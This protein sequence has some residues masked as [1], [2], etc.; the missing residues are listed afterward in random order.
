M[1]PG[2]E[3]IAPYLQ[4][5]AILEVAKRC[6]ADAIHPGYGFLSESPE[7]AA[8][9][10]AQNIKF[11]GPPPSA[12]KL[13]GDKTAAKDLAIRNNVPVA[14]GSPIL[15]TGQ[16]AVEFARKNNV[17]FPI[18]IKAAF[19]GGGRGQKL[20][21]NEKELLEG[22]ELCAKEALL[23]FGDGSCFVEE[24][25][26]HARHIEVQIIADSKHD[27]VSVYE[28]DCSVQLRNQKVIEVA[29]ARDMCA[30]LRTSLHEC[31]KRLAAAAGYVNAGTVEFLVRG[32]LSNEATTFIF[33]E[34]NPRI[35]VEHTITEEVCKVDLVRSQI[36]I[37]SG[38]SLSE[39]GLVQSKIQAHGFAIQL[40]VSL[41]PGKE[42]P[43]TQYTEPQGPGIRVDSGV[44]LGRTP[45]SQYDPMISKLIVYVD[46]KEGFDACI[47]KALAALDGYTMEGIR[48]NKDQLHAIL[49]HP[50]FVQNKVL[51]TFMKD[52]AQELSKKPAL[53]PAKKPAKE[54]AAPVFAKIKIDAPF[55]GKVAEVR[56]KVG[57]KIEGNQVLTV[58]SAMKMMNEINSPVTGTVVE[59][60]PKLVV[61]TQINEGDMMLVVEGYVMEQEQGHE[62]EST[63]PAAA[64]AAVGGGGGFPSE[65]YTA[66]WFREGT[67]YG[68]SPA[69]A[70]IRSKI[71][72]TTDAYKKR[73][74]HNKKVIGELQARLNLVKEGGGEK[75]VKVHRSRGKLLPRERVE[76][77]VDEGTK[78]LELSALAAWGLY[79]NKVH[80]AGMVCGIG[81]VHGTECMFIINDAT[82]KGG[83][84]FPETLKKMYRAQAIAQENHLP[85][86][87]L[88]DGGGAN[89]SA[90]EGNS[91]QGSAAAFVAGGSQFY[92]QA[93]MSSLGIP[94]ISA[95]LG[96]CTAGGAYIP[97]MSDENV[98]VKG[99]GTI[100]LGGPPLVKAAT[101]EVANEQDLGGAAM[102][103]SKSGVADHLAET[104]EEALQKVRCI[105]EHLARRPRH[106]LPMATPE[107]PAYDVDQLLGII[108]EDNKFPFDIREVIARI[109][110]GSRFHEFKPRYGI[111]LVCGFAHIHGFPV[112]ILANNGMLFSDSAIKGTHF[113]QVCGQRGIPLVFLHNI[114]GF[115]VGTQ[116]EQGGIAKDGAKM[117][118]AVSCV[119]VPKFSVVI[120][121]SHGAGNYAMCGPAFGPR[122]TFL[123]PNA[124]ISVMGGPQ[125]AEVITIVKNDQ[126][127][128]EGKPQLT[129]EQKAKMQ[130]PILKLYETSSSSYDSTKAVWDDGVIDPRD[131]RDV[132]AQAISISLNAPFPTNGYGV[133]RM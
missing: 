24:F 13:F 66:A 119:P 65:R 115:M 63:K 12:L 29:P 50:L 49:M 57:D 28:R 82:V 55:P 126:L 110:D 124:K 125:A 107:P 129:P 84:L 86:I 72:T 87:Y 94:Q 69:T 2:T 5:P 56:V 4:I 1:L 59:I 116:Y 75:A 31:A 100:Y 90:A 118:M 7:F 80:S 18:L 96:K 117:I 113:I 128:R 130:A 97:A 36:L 27:V 68:V 74:E 95:V 46:Q 61:D 10:A 25:F 123:W 26:Q 8:A 131:T 105:V 37:A 38:V 103:T 14:K 99:N 21:F 6:G 42:Q 81:I 114:T 62:A 133:F 35:Q 58:V 120:G 132:L 85:C 23:T 112:G 108:P 30:K 48:V 19:G 77:I 73:Y 17:P 88:V 16:E 104:E 51:T 45:S 39:L 54:K 106:V 33:L 98:I 41:M 11:V 47:A 76:K 71:D 60:S 67:G 93:V 111:T 32:D 127:K 43:I 34:M 83:V 101:G 44:G 53:T 9:C 20:T 121:G 109:V 122:F 89:L 78:F 79:G 22:F 102:H 70:K 64:A 52:Q 92:N 91:S 3:A 40:R 15:K